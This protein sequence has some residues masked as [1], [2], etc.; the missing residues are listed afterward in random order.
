MNKIAEL[1]GFFKNALRPQIRQV[2]V[3]AHLLA[4]KF[5]DSVLKEHQ[6]TLIKAVIIAVDLEWWE[7]DSKKVT[8]IGISTL[9]ACE[10]TSAKPIHQLTGMDVH[11]LRLKENAHLVNGKL[12]DGFP[13]DFSFGK[14]VFVDAAEA[15]QALN[16]IFVQPDEN[17]ETRPVILLGHAVDNDVDVLRDHFGFDLAALGNLIM[18]LDTQ[19]MAAE[20]GLYGGK[21]M[22]L[23][24][25]LGQYCI[26]DH[27]LHNA[28]NDAGQTMVAATLLAGECATGKGRYDGGNQ[29]DVE[30][31]KSNSR[32]RS[33]LYWGVP[34]FCTNCESNTHLVSACQ[35][36]TV[37]AR[38]SE[39]AVKV[40][41]VP[42]L[43][44]PTEKCSLFNFPCA[45][46]MDSG[47]IERKKMAYTHDED[48][49]PGVES[50]K[51]YLA[52]PKNRVK[53]Y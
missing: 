8:E 27:H 23:K 35:K 4:L 21:K 17:N 44:H 38:C 36:Q 11:H 1:R 22:S 45:T 52:H 40:G 50:R 15:N 26:E 51:A 49:C 14:T 43:D 13:E 32:S 39:A 31:V 7:F 42:T 47:N 6:S 3:M 20:L 37:C 28:G 9:A 19:I 33:G 10:K 30:N 24:H 48:R 18:V 53:K 12:C 29:A 2:D 34:T 46:C 25:I 41:H 16:T 5:S